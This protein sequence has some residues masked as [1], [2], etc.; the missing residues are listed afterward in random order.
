MMFVSLRKILFPLRSIDNIWTDD[1]LRWDGFCDEVASSFNAGYAVLAIAHFEETL[2]ALAGALRDHSI[3]S[4]AYSSSFDMSSLGSGRK[5][6]SVWTCLSANVQEQCG[7][8]YLIPHRKM[9]FVVAERYPVPG[10][11]EALLA[12]AKSL[13]SVRKVVYHIALTDPL[14]ARFDTKSI[15]KLIDHLG[16]SRNECIHHPVIRRAIRTAQQ[17]IAKCVTDEILTRSA[18]DWFESNM[19]V[20]KRG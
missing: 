15:V 10:R 17:R 19:P 16:M 18:D 8:P 7:Q 14:L 2:G 11:D 1:R 9:V 4:N 3:E 5:S 20:G 13:R 6:P 12:V